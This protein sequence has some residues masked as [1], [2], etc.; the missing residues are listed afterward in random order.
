MNGKG[1]ING[2]V[3]SVDLYRQFK[4]EVEGKTSSSV[5]LA[6]LVFESLDKEGNA[7][8]LAEIA[9][10]E[11]ELPLFVKKVTQKWS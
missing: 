2:S 8:N 11:E 5:I 9:V 1:T 3:C 7:L 10:L 6:S 4:V